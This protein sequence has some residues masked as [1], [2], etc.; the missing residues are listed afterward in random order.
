MTKEDTLYYIHCLMARH[1]TRVP[2]WIERSSQEKTVPDI[3]GK[4][5]YLIERDMTIGQV[6]YIIRRRILIND[7]TALFIFVD[8]NVLPPNNTSIGELYKSHA[9]KDGML[10]IT[11]RAESTFG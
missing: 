3:D 11:Y 9:Y 1:P 2:C 5:K 7:K 8:G 10:Y 4:K 6:M